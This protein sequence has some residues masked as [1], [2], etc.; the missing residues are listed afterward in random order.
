MKLFRRVHLVCCSDGEAQTRTQ[1]RFRLDT[2][3]AKINAGDQR[4]SQ[5]AKRL[6]VDVDSQHCGPATRKKGI[7]DALKQRQQ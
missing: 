6:G 3:G 5:L 4:Q 7:K 2:K 1:T